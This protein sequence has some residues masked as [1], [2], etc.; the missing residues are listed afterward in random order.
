MTVLAGALVLS[1]F[2]APTAQ[3]AGTGITV[4][5]IVVNGGK[6]VVVGTSDVKEPRITFRVHLPA[7][8]STADFSAWDAEPYLYHGTT[9][10]KGALDGS[11]QASYTCYETAARISDCEGTLYIEPRYRL[12]SNND[13]TTWKIGVAT[14]LWGANWKL[15]KEQ[16]TTAPGGVQIRRWAK[17]TVNASPE[18][19]KKG[20][21][22]T[23]TGSLKRADW[24]KHTYTGVAAATV[25][26]QFRKKGGSAYTTVKTVRSSSSGALKTT[27]KASADGYWRWSFGGWSTTGAATSAV[28]FVDV[29]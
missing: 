10:E 26:L 7:G 22:L 3:A 17:A 21:T 4:T 28:D 11:L 6:P 20:G 25:K 14:K 18:P 15:K 27:V 8:Y 19:V 16:Y 12:D 24:V 13:A 9:A 5:G 29:R 2:T 1:A 23:V